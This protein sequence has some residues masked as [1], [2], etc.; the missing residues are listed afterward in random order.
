VETKTK[1]TP[2]GLPARIAK[3]RTAARWQLLLAALLTIAAAANGA[4]SALAPT[5][6]GV[7][8]GAVIL[9]C[10]VLMWSFLLT[11]RTKVEILEIVRSEMEGGRGDQ[12]G[13]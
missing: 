13:G 1:G 10:A 9:S 12:P 7:V 3:L 2:E 11:I 4:S 6:I 5:R 8:C